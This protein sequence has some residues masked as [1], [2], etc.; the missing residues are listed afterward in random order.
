MSLRP[1]DTELKR[2]MSPPLSLLMLAALTPSRHE[3][4]IA[5][6]NVSPLPRFEG[7]DLAGI[8]VNV[9]ASPRAYEIAGQLRKCG[10]P[11]VMGG[12]HAS[13]CPEE[14][15]K[16]A[17][18]VCVGEAETVW[19][20][21]LTD[22]GQKQLRVRYQAKEAVDL[23][24]VPILDRSRIPMDAYL[25]SNI[26]MASRGCCFCCEFCYNSCEY[27]NKTYRTRPIG[28][29]IAEIDKIGSRQ[30][31]FIDD[32]LI[33]DTRWTKELLNEI[34]SRQL[35]WHGAVSANIGRH[36]ELLDLMAETGCRS[37]FIGF[38]SLNSQALS[39]AGKHHNRVPQY[40]ETIRQIHDRGIMIN[41]SMVFGF[42]DDTVDVFP[43]TL[44]WLV[45]NQV[46]TLTSH[47]LTP[48]PGTKLHQRLSDEGRIVDTDPRHYNTS[49]AVFSPKRMSREE[50]RQGY[51][52]I[53]DEFYSWANIW[54]RLPDDPKRRTAFL[55]FN[56]GYRK[57]G[58]VTAM[59]GKMRMMRS[60]G[61]LARKLSYGID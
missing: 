2:R 28:E 60:I 39:E 19:E 25:Y 29:I 35:V 11:V 4:T 33:G 12:I 10:I 44:N 52:W 55:L 46:E 1:M 20:Q 48:Y 43:T 17:T 24:H 40:E 34:K 18:S 6:E 42:D 59:I 37:L 5:D 51:L 21:I 38:E 23:R 16:H 36:P 53:Y 58:R 32:N 45:S 54:R 3:I 41:A 49:Y 56:L 26:M 50:L 22:A 7:F 13:A 8:T 27:V 9:D 61:S 14:V 47:I 30:I 31:M 57:F 15:G